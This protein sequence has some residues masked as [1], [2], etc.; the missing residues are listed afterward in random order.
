MHHRI[1]AMALSI[2]ALA[3][4]LVAVQPPP[5]EA[6]I[7]R[8]AGA[9]RFDTSVRVSEA[10]GASRG[11][12]VY[13]A[14]GLAFP[15]ALA[16]APVAAAED[17]RLLLAAPWDIP[18]SVVAEIRDLAPREI[19]LVGGEPSLN[20]AV[21][22]EA[23]GLAPAVT[24]I[25][26]ADR[27][28]T[29]MLLLDR[30][31]SLPVAQPTQLWIVSGWNFPDALAA[32]AVAARDGHAL[33]L[34]GGDQPAFRDML[35]SRMGGISRIN[36]AGGTPSVSDAVVAFAGT[37][38]TTN[39]YA[40]S[41]R[42]Q[43]AVVIN[44]AFTSRANGARMLLA[45]GQNFPD[46]L[47]ASV[48]A[49]HR[50]QPLYL[51]P[52]ACVLDDAVAGEVSRLGIRDTTVIG[53]TPSVSAAASR[54]ERCVD[55]GAVQA[56]V[57][58]IVNAH[59]TGIGLPAL[60]AHPGLTSMAQGWSGQ[61]AAQQSMV[62][63]TTFC[64]DTFAMGFRRCAENVARTGSASAAGV[65]NAWMNSAGHRANILNPN[66]THIGVGVVQGPDGRWYWTQNFGGF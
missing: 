33:V 25:A 9:D 51:V 12:V 18:D 32:G 24:R 23:S 31:R 37:L 61:M 50:G 2:A 38:A 43:T 35:A 56:E 5:A 57:V 17:A 4:A 27:V 20:E 53:G 10:M 48:L 49:A 11:G 40:G 59:R 14:N 36:V 30:L 13:L 26:G 42:F 44:R 62:H 3:T 66:L 7:D 54:L 65:M 6:A 47:V 21:R 41:D 22:A 45:S 39:R 15:D 64:D 19:V 34:T 46:G 58:S 55:L 16:A 1:A 52:Q 60:A 8:I 63:S 28:E 29:S